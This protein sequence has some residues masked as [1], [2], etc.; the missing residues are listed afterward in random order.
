MHPVL[1]ITVPCYNEEAV[2]QETVKRLS[3][4]LDNM[5]QEQELVDKGSRILLVNDGSA[6]S[7]WNIIRQLHGSNSYVCGLNLAGNVGHQNA[8]MAGLETAK[9]MGDAIIS[10]DADLQDDIAVIPEMIRKYLDGC[11]IVYGVRKERKTDTWSRAS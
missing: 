1:I 2:L 7:T 4:L 9:D 5:I 6:D 8:L 11:D 3:G 10:I